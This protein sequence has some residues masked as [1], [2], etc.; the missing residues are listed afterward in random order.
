VSRRVALPGA[1]ELFRQT[2]SH[3]GGRSTRPPLRAVAPTETEPEPA[4]STPVP[5]GAAGS[6]RARH[7]T[8]ITVYLS[9]DELVALEKARLVLRADHGIAVDRS[10]IVRE[11]VSLVLSDLDTHGYDAVLVRRL[12]DR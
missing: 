6:R 1:A 12:A 7:D 10:R 5:G 4:Q 2:T 3:T 8:K 9:T 11:A